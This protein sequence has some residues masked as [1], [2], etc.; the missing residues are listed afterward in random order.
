MDGWGGGLLKTLY[1]AIQPRFELQI[2]FCVK[3]SL[4]FT[5]TPNSVIQ[6]LKVASTDNNNRFNNLFNGIVY[7]TCRREIFDLYIIELSQAL[8]KTIAPKLYVQH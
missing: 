6:Y 7:D 2:F 3:K 1:H 8:K 4:W 5:L